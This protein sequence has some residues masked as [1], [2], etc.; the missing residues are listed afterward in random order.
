MAKQ[1]SDR[2]E[3]MAGG[4]LKF[5]L[6]PAGA[7]V[8]GLRGAEC[9]SYGCAR[10]CS[11]GTAYWYGKKA[12]SLFGTGPVFGCDA[13]QMLAWVQSEEERHAGSA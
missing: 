10:C 13:A 3:K 8:K 1:Y 2:R 11:R 5:D 6:L 4:G 7:V 9:V 12:A